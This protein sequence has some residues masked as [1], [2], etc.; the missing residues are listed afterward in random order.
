MNMGIIINTTKNIKAIS[1]QKA[2]KRSDYLLSLTNKEVRYTYALLFYDYY[3][4]IADLGIYIE[5]NHEFQGLSNRKNTRVCRT[6]L[7]I[8]Q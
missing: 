2:N 3:H 1:W 5:F 6:S 8:A 4:E 7:S